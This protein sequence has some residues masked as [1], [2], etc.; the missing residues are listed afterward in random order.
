MAGLGDALRGAV[1]F[2]TRVPVGGDED[3]WDAF[4]RA[5]AS[6]PAAGY[7][8][9]A[10]LALTIV[11]PGPEPT[12]AIAFLAA[13]YLLTGINHVDG[14]ADVG[15]AI[16]THGDGAAKRSAMKDTDT[17]VGALVAVALAVAG[18]A[19]AGLALA[20]LPPGI[21][22]GIVVA[23]E[24]GV[25]L[26]VA[27]LVCVGST[28][29]EGLGSQ[30]VGE[31]TASDALGPTAVALP[32]ALLTWPTPAALAALAGAALAAWLAYRW[33]NAALGGV[34]GD[35]LGAANE[36]GRV[37]ALHTGVIAWTLS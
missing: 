3:A 14:L 21:A 24:V 16:A 33:A 34:S 7:A 28:A 5:P 37:V 25:K 10:A 32:A 17:G 1:G 18:L 20:A 2:L 31:S 15:D 6:I 36:L 19:L 23:G 12:V 26:A 35:V 22:M 27:L 29:H 11:V 30:L 4:R 13:V 8:I 9:G